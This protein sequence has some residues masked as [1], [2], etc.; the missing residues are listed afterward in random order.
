MSGKTSIS[1]KDMSVGKASDINNMRQ[2][3]EDY[4]S[5]HLTIRAEFEALK[6]LNEELSL[7]HEK[8]LKELKL[9]LRIAKRDADKWRDHNRY[10]RDEKKQMSDQNNAFQTA[11]EQL[12]EQLKAKDQQ[13]EQLI[14]Q[15]KTLN[16]EFNAN[17]S[18]Q[19]V[20]KELLYFY[21]LFIIV[22]LIFRLI[23]FSIY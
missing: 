4:E 1:A 9:D 7:R 12:K 14:H 6:Q 2:R 23:L 22:F 15:I 10:L 5:K 3:L 13:I 8:Q 11:N 21:C 19:K 16:D 17:I 18:D 20:V